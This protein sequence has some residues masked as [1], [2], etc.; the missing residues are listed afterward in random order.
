MKIF[1]LIA[2]VRYILEI[3]VKVYQSIAAYIEAR[4]NAKREKE[5]NDRIANRNE[6]LDQIAVEAHNAPTAESDEELRRLHR[7]L[8]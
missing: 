4:K 2:N 8:K 1:L 7:E 3:I 6:T 5:Y